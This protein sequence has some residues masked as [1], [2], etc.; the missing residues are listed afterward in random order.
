MTP[1]EVQRQF[2]D[3]VDFLRFEIDMIPMDHSRTIER[4]TGM[5]NRFKEIP[6]TE[7]PFKEWKEAILAYYKSVP[8][9]HIIIAKKVLEKF[10]TL[11]NRYEA[12]QND[13]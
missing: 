2:E 4:I 11:I 10:Q 1:E 9:H 3:I 6:G 8:N 12:E 13:S 5:E 7:E